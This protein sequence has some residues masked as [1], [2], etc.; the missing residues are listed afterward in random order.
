[1]VMD[2]TVINQGVGQSKGP[3]SKGCLPVTKRTLGWASEGLEG[4]VIIGVPWRW[5]ETFFLL[6]GPSKRLSLAGLP[7]KVPK[8][9]LSPTCVLDHH[10]GKTQKQTD[11][12]IVHRV[13]SYNHCKVL[14]LHLKGFTFVVLLAIS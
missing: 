2:C 3:A 6:S 1:M 8:G 5:L 12:D 14:M 13:G 11:N 9:T 10:F 4:Y 7:A